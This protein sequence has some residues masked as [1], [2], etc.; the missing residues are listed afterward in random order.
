MKEKRLRDGKRGPRRGKLSTSGDKPAERADAWRPLRPGSVRRRGSGPKER[1]YV[2]EEGGKEHHLFDPET[3]LH[4]GKHDGKIG[5]VYRV[6]DDV[7]RWHMG[8]KHAYSGSNTD[9]GLIPWDGRGGE[10]SLRLAAALV[11]L[12]KGKVTRTP[13]SMIEYLCRPGI[14]GRQEFWRKLI[15]AH[16]E[17]SDLGIIQEVMES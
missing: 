15:V 16:K 12:V 13:A 11:A 3:S 9:R 4:V 17:A 14:W 8:D 1:R 2:L 7:R 6:R 5:I 10:E